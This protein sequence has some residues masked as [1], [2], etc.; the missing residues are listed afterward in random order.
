MDLVCAVYIDITLNVSLDI[1]DCALNNQPCL[2]G[3]QCDDKVNNYVCRCAAGYTG[4]NCEIS[5]HMYCTA[6]NLLQNKDV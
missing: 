2:N 5:K 4:T 3:G 6:E 1:D